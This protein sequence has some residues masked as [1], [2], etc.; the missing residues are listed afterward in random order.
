MTVFTSLE[1]MNRLKCA[2]MATGLALEAAGLF[3]LQSMLH[4][5]A[6]AQLWLDLTSSQVWP[7]GYS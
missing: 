1:N 6:G 4:P 7:L 3:Y 2:E 5:G